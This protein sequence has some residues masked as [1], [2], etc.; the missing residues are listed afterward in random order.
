MRKKMWV[1]GIVIV[2]VALWYANAYATGTTRD[3]WDGAQA[4][5]SGFWGSLVGF[6]NNALPWNWGNWVGK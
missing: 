4:S 1:V 3:S 5:W 6:F 2:L